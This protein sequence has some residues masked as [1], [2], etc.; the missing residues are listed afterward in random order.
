M[1][2]VRDALVLAESTSVPPERVAVLLEAA[3]S[4]PLVHAVRAAE[5]AKRPGVALRDVF[6]AMHVGETLPSEALIGA[7][8]EIKYAGYFERERTRADRLRALSAMP[9]SRD[10][11]FMSMRTLSTE[12]RH[13]LD[14]LRPASLGDA[15][16]IPGISPSDLQ[17]LVFEL[18]RQ[19]RTA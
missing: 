16:Q 19:R 9:L 11:D 6:A 13:K 10:L 7:E 5:I 18:E 3:Q 8:L 12:A 1:A 14:A 4:A 15:S 17:N 2:S